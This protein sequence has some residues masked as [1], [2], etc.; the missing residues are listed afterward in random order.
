MKRR[1]DEE[2]KYDPKRIGRIKER[3]NV[4]RFGDDRCSLYINENNGR[5]SKRNW[6]AQGKID[7]GRNRGDWPFE[8]RQKGENKIKK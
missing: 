4:L 1:C 7:M 2:K 5:V 6:K 8:G 3:I